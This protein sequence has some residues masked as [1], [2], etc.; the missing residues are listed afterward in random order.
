MPVVEIWLP[1]TSDAMTEGLVER[2]VAEPETLVAAGEVIA[3]IETEKAV[4]ELT[5]TD[6]GV[7]VPAV[8]AGVAVA[9]G[10]PLAY[11][12]TGEDI[13]RYRDGSL[14][15]GSTSSP[16]AAG[17]PAQSA[18][19][20]PAPEPSTETLKS[21]VDDPSVAPKPSRP[22]RFSSPLARKVAKELGLRLDDIGP[23]SGPGERIT[24]SDVVEAARN[25]A[26]GGGA[27][28]PDE[29][30]WVEVK[31]TPRES[32]QARAMTTAKTEIPHFYVSRIV[33]VGAADTF[34]RELTAASGRKVTV[35]ALLLK[36]TGLA[37]RDLE[38]PRRVWNQGGVREATQIDIG[39]AVASG[40]QNLVVAVIRQADERPLVDL[41]QQLE[42][43]S[44]AARTNALRPEQLSGAVLTISNLGMHGVDR[45]IPIIPPGQSAILGVGATRRT[46]VIAE[47][48][49]VRPALTVEI[50]LAG[51]HRVLTGLGAALFLER[52]DHYLQHPLALVTTTQERS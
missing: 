46:P 47:D 27:A 38:F 52:I 36:A 29:G 10:S 31:L 9:V 11:V 19:A 16:P 5:S 28:Y 1:R 37:V 45:V 20:D 7:L 8:A 32:A 41:V 15:V 51:D 22:T 18:S 17:A 25:T 3:E 50:T 14:S 2:W 42:I 33:D 35:T 39:V 6:S 24:R 34:R 40:P 12:I 44:E 30:D 4:V 23:G 21:A 13:D 48:G 43:L 26:K 49:Q